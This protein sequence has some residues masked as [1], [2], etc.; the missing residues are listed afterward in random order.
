MGW[1]LLLAVAAAAAASCMAALLLSKSHDSRAPGLLGELL[2]PLLTSAIRPVHHFTST[3]ASSLTS[4]YSAAFL[5]LPPPVFCRLFA[6]LFSS[7]FFLLARSY[8]AGLP[9][10]SPCL[11]P[12]LPH[13]C[14]YPSSRHFPCYIHYF[15]SHTSDLSLV[16]TSRG[17]ENVD[18]ASLRSVVRSYFDDCDRNVMRA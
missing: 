13:R 7:F 17:T 4:L 1:R 5:P 15:Q 18:Q 3:S 12:P 11:P 8:A 2:Q 9:S 6:S 10:S 16:K 14:T